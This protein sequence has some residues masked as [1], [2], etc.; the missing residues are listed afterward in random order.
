MKIIQT[1][2]SQIEEETRGVKEYAEM[3][4]ANKDE[5]PD[6]ANTYHRLAEEEMGHVNKLHDAV[7]SL[8]KDYRSKQGEPPAPMMAV[9]EYLHKRHIEAAAE[10]QTLLDMF[11]K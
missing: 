6:L 7:V 5:H 8:I 9:Y 10:A 4:L 11:K 3:A 2:S 1:L